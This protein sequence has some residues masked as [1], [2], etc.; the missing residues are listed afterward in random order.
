MQLKGKQVVVGITGGIAAYKTC[1]IVS[2]LRKKGADVYCIMTKNATE[3]VAPLTFETLSNNPVCV[4]MFARIKSWE[5]EHISLAKRAGLF[6]IAP[7]TANFIA[8]LNSGICDDMLT[9]TVLATKAP[10]LICPA[11]N[12]NM[13]ENPITQRNIKAL[14]ALGYLFEGPAEGWLAEG[15]SGRGRMSEPDVITARAEA[16]LCSKK[17]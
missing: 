8:K 14:E 3:F 16:I 7:A 4:D 12:E 17:I 13:Y 5:V 2:S 10:V 15:I 1:Q 6:V 11:M 9:T